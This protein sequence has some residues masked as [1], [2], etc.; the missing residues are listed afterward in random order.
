M[1]TQPN[2]PPGQK[3]SLLHIFKFMASGEKFDGLAFAK[4]NDDTFGASSYSELG[5]VKM[6]QF[7][8]PELIH[9]ILVE[10]ADKFHKGA[11]MKRGLV[12]FI[13]NGLVTS[14]GDF[15]RRQ[16]K[17]AQPAFHAKRIENYAGTMVDHTLN[18]LENWRDGRTIRIDREM[19]K[20]T[21]GIA[22]KTLFD[23]DVSGDAERVAVLLAEV[24]DITN[25]RFSAVINLPEW[26]P[27]PKRAR[28]AKL[29]AELDAI[30]QRFIDER[31]KTNEDRGDLLSML[32]L[33]EDENGEHMSDKQLRDEVMTLF[34]AG[35]E[36]T[37]NALTWAWYLLSQ[38]AEVRQKLW[39]EV[40]SV[41]GGRAPTLADLSNLPYSDR[42]IK[43]ALR[44]YPPAPGMNREPIED[45]TVGGY[46]VPK[47]VQLSLS[48]YAMHRSA[49]YFENPEQFEPERFSPEREKQI[50]RYAYLPFG[51]GPRVCIGNMFAMMEARLVLATVAARY[52][53][54]LLPE[55]QVVPEQLVTIRPRYGIQ[56]QTIA[57]TSV[58]PTTNQ[59]E[60]V[61]V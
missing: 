40:D 26:L 16:R 5:P 9:E 48:I 13:G 21:L 47:G 53:L 4:F 43:E 3:M 23:T 7:A 6:Y 28:T 24:L 12:P 32:I 60:K 61:S 49:R 17:L 8:D 41:L 20:L 19:M 29:I 45:V 10:K 27:T 56:M 22:C 34:F 50:P 44:L 51:G 57:R 25:E 31:R 36:T 2:Y 58:T 39:A 59:A 15:W 54:A 33:A 46:D 35:H 37:A 42:V 38:H 14:D 11:V 18:M 52:D 55:P 30:I 1:T